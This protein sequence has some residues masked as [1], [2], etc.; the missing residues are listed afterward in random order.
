MNPTNKFCP[1][2][3]PSFSITDYRPSKSLYVNVHN[4]NDFRLFMQHNGLKVMKKNLQNFA[5]TMNCNC[6]SK[7]D[8]KSIPSFNSD[9]LNK[10]EHGTLW[11][12]SNSI[13]KYRGYPGGVKT[14]I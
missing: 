7:Y 5:T 9:L 13:K 6:E 1:S 10:A 11:T 12:N 3:I 8:S 4:N 14:N 2:D